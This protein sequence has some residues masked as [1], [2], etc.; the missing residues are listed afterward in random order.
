VIRGPFHQLVGDGCVYPA[1]VPTL[2][3]QLTG[4]HLSWKAYLQDMGNTPSRDRTTATSQGP[5]CGHPAV[6][7][8]DPTEGATAAD[9]YATRHEGFMYFESVIG[10]QA[11][12]DAHV[13][14]YRFSVRLGPGSGLSVIS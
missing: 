9:Q 1:S 12:C 5:A 6:G 14:R 11:Y 10:N 2:G 3:N 4:R 13:G 8:A 7:T